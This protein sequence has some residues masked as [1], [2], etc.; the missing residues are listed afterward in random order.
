M[1]TVKSKLM[2]WKI[3]FLQN[4]VLNWKRWKAWTKVTWY[5]RHS[6]PSVFIWCKIEIV[7]SYNHRSNRRKFS[8]TEDRQVFWKHLMRAEVKTNKRPTLNACLWNFRIRDK[9][10]LTKYS[11][12]K[13]SL[14]A[15]ERMRLTLGLLLI[16]NKW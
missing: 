6:K 13:H 8:Q 3:E 4:T 7:W 9:E 1:D 15:K 11:E 14:S 12:S 5:R 16:K 2:N 10:E